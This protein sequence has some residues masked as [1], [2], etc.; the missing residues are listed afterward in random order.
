MGHFVISSKKNLNE[1]EVGERI[2]ES[3][4]STLTTDGYFCQMKYVDDEEMAHGETATPGIFS[5][6]KTMSGLKLEKTQYTTD[7]VLKDFVNTKE[8][9]DKIDK[10]VHAIPKYEKFGIFPKRG[11]LLY[12][13]AGS[14]KTTILAESSRKYKDE[15]KTFILLWHTDKID[16]GDVKDFIK[17]LKYEGVDK[18]IL[19][20]EDIGGI[21]IDQARIRSES[22]LLSLLDN[23]ESTF[24]VPVLILATTNYPENFMGNL[25]NR[26]NRFDDKIR[27]GYP[28][29][30]HRQELLKFYDK[31]GVVGE[32][33]LVLI[34]D[35]KC[36]EFTPAHLRE[37]II[38][39]AIYDFTP[40]D[41]IKQMIEEVA[42]FN[43]AFTEKAKNGIGLSKSRLLDDWD[44]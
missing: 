35:K 13:P 30:K 28:K 16:A 27:V 18:M 40:Q 10:F 23:Q 24:K 8:V 6:L 15:G 14:G 38:R 36:D 34:A 39:S 3:D 4:F 25:T 9:T 19:I 12:G 31:D 42:E 11:I 32:E 7:N 26:P 5:M 20:A 17:H 29:S 22:A 44:N 2:D 1:M 21:E 33:A 41:V 37:I 43:R